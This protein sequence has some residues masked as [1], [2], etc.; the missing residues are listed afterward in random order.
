MLNVY[1]SCDRCR[2]VVVVVA[3]IVVVV[4][5]VEYL[6]TGQARYH[7]RFRLLVHRVC[8]QKLAID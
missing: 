3:A 2:A 1:V 7:T 8:S 6:A 5:V 4:V